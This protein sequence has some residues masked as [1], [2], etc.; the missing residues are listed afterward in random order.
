M[1]SK[2]QQLMCLLFQSTKTA[3]AT[4]SSTTPPLGG[5][6]R[7]AAQVNLAAADKPSDVYTHVSTAVEKEVMKDAAAG[8]E[9]AML[10]QG[11][12]QERW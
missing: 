12:F 5:D 6:A 3:R 2:I 11:K 8:H 1:S 7:G 9:I 10:L 4:V